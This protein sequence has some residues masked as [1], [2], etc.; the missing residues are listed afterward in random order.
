MNLFVLL[1]NLCRNAR[2]RTG[3]HKRETSLP[4]SSAMSVCHTTATCHRF[5]GRQCLSRMRASHI[6][7]YY[8]IWSLNLDY[9][10]SGTHQ[11]RAARLRLCQTTTQPTRRSSRRTLTN[12][13]SLMHPSRP[14]HDVLTSKRILFFSTDIYSEDCFKEKNFFSAS[15]STWEA[16]QT[17]RRLPVS[18]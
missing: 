7:V 17:R 11:Q 3:M 13:R 1:K 8:Q 15:Y 9:C 12:P 5:T 6:F 16:D 10:K 2:H 18:C 14:S 4:G